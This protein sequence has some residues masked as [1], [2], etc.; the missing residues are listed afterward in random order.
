MRPQKPTN[1]GHIQSSFYYIELQSISIKSATVFFSWF[2]PAVCWMLGLKYFFFL[3]VFLGISFTYISWCTFCAFSLFP[4]LVCTIWE[5]RALSGYSVNYRVPCPTWALLCHL[6]CCMHPWG[7]PLVQSM[8]IPGHCHSQNSPLP[9]CALQFGAQE[10]IPWDLRRPP[11]CLLPSTHSSLTTQRLS[12]DSDIPH[13]EDTGVSSCWAPGPCLSSQL[14][15]ALLGW[16]LTY[17]EKWTHELLGSFQR[18]LGSWN[19]PLKGF[20]NSCIIHS[21]SFS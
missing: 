3:L 2:Y 1:I 11:K 21:F 10:M 18:N 19:L 20:I 12:G 4:F 15:E 6:A 8:C 14:T 16:L 13:W 7:G 9:H 17:W 5:L